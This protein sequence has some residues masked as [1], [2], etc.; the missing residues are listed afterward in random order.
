MPDKLVIKL[1]SQQLV[2][3]EKCPR[4]FQLE[5]LRDLELY[6]K[7]KVVWKETNGVVTLRLEPSEQNLLKAKALRK[8]GIMADA[9]DA[10]YKGIMAGKRQQECILLGWNIITTNKYEDTKSESALEQYTSLTKTY[11]EYCTYYKDDN[12]IPVSSETGFSVQIHEDD[13]LI[14]IYEGKP[15][16]TFRYEGSYQV[17][18]MD[19]K[20]ESARNELH[21]WSNQFLGYAYA[22]K[23]YKLVVNYI[24]FQAKKAPSEKFLRSQ[25]FYSPADLEDWRKNVVRNVKELVAFHAE[26]YYPKRRASCETKY[27]RCVFTRLCDTQIPWLIEARTNNFFRARDIKWSAWERSADEKEDES[28]E[29]V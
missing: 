22:L 23:A 9:L 7:W 28:S 27:G 16:L 10:Y 11:A 20:T 12:I 18:P 29:S 5:F 8:G 25:H 26:N 24:G 19:H 21:G 17:L 3:F 1:D 14:I 4:R 6:G 13:D 2:S 15:D